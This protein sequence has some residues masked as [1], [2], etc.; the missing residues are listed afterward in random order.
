MK[1]KKKLKELTLKDNFMFRQYGE[2]KSFVN[3]R[4]DI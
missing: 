4:N 3:W 1:K 2:S